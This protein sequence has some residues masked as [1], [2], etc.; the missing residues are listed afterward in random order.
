M[1]FQ[2][3]EAIS[4]PTR[5]TG[6]TV[7]FLALLLGLAGVD[8]IN[9]ADNSLVGLKV[10]EHKFIPLLEVFCIV[11][12]VW[13]VVQWYSDFLSF[14]G[15]NITGGTPRTSFL[16]P[17]MTR[18][19]RV[20]DLIMNLSEVKNDLETLPTQIEQIRR[21]LSGLDWSIRKFNTFARF[22]VYCWHL[23]VP[24]VAVCVAFLVGRHA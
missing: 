14:R 23:A 7:L 17:S 3:K 24:L 22:Y 13:H 9:V 18:L 15:W 16:K 8:W 1:N 5:A 20:A 11:A 2:G 21:E 10:N 4:R 12:A 19:E 6:R